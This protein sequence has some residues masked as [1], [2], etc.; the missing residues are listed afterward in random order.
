MKPGAAAPAPEIPP[1]KIFSK[2]RRSS[3][4]LLYRQ[5]F[6][7]A[8]G[9]R[10][11][12]DSVDGAAG[13]SA[14]G[15]GNRFCRLVNRDRPHS[16]LRCPLSRMDPGDSGRDSASRGTCGAGFWH[17]RLPVRM[18]HRTVAFLS[19]GQA[20]DISLSTESFQIHA[21][22]VWFLGLAG[23]LD[24]L[25]EAYLLT[26]KV[27]KAR[28][29]RAFDL[30]SAFAGLLGGRINRMLIENDP[31]EP[32]WVGAA[33]EA[34]RSQ[35]D[36]EWFSGSLSK[37]S[38]TGFREI[39]GLGFA[40]LAQRIRLEQ[41]CCRLLEP[42]FPRS[43]VPFRAGFQTES[44]MEKTFS[45]YLGCS[46]DEYRDRMAAHDRQLADG[47]RPSVEPGTRPRWRDGNGL[48]KPR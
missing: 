12:L 26:P 37:I 9:L 27:S 32:E 4:W 35:P 28:L 10:L 44:E 15:E 2:L 46:P 23:Q 38:E 25:A 29:E 5:T 33:R 43:R 20:A 36:G 40:G 3:E 1:E 41:A 11:S 48:A 39:T 19:V 18:G 31:R 16:C 30:A 34:I 14:A 7:R 47:M 6:V 13:P 8:T 24:D 17:A 21:A 42:G 45:I 22:G